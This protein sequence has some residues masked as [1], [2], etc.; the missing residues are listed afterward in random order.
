M[1]VLPIFD[2]HAGADRLADGAR[3]DSPQAQH[4]WMIANGPDL[5]VSKTAGERLTR[6]WQSASTNGVLAE[7]IPRLPLSRYTTWVTCCTVT[8]TQAQ[9]AAP[10]C[11]WLAGRPCAWS[12]TTCHC[13]PRRSVN[14][15]V[16]QTRS[17]LCQGGRCGQARAGRHR[18]PAR[19]NWLLQPV[20]DDGQRQCWATIRGGLGVGWADTIDNRKSHPLTDL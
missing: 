15:A 13:G 16:N 17:T 8:Q 5:P 7:P 14:A 9:T 18:E 3:A 12:W 20:A 19:R 2:P 10:L 4:E 11:A 6:S 1:C